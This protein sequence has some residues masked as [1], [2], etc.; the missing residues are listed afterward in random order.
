VP[1]PSTE[2]VDDVQ[3]TSGWSRSGK[4]QFVLLLS[5]I[6]FW[7]AI[8]GWTLIVDSEDLRPPGRMEDTAFAVDA[9]PVCAATA[10]AIADLGLP[11][12]VE[13]PLERAELVD[14]E[15]ELLSAMVV[16]LRALDRPEGEEGT[17]VAEWLDDWVT[18]IADRQAWADQLREGDD[19]PFV[20]TARQGE[21]I[22]KG[23]DYFAE[24]NDMPSC[25]TAGDV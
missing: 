14:A 1:V 15:N 20:E 19:G 13:T 7:L 5:V 22:S 11:T 16:D 6:L 21:Q 17:W 24:T 8:L 25:A 10:T 4:V 9:E 3:A 12:A 18:H 23:I 2:P